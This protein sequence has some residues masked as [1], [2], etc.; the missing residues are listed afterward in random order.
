MRDLK[1]SIEIEGMVQDHEKRITKIEIDD[2]RLDERIDGLASS[3]NNLKWCV[4][5]FTFLCL[6]ALIYGALGAN[7]F[8]Q[9]IKAQPQI[10]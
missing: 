10:Q 7:G 3:T 8:N 9:V 4:W 1:M 2:A 5:G 6:L